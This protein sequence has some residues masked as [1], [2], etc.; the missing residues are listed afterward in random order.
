MCLHRPGPWRGGPGEVV[1]EGAVQ[2][3]GKRIVI[4]G[5]GRGMGEATLGAYVREGASV[6]AIDVRPVDVDRFDGLGKAWYVDCDVSDRAQVDAA[7][8]EA[9]GLLGGLDVLVVT[10][11][12]DLVRPAA[13]I[14]DELW[15][16]TMAINVRGTMLTNQAAYRLMKPAGG[17]A[18]INFGSDSGLVPSMRSAAYS[19]SKAAVHQWTRAIAIEWGPD[20]IRAN[21]VL[22]AIWTPIAEERVAQLSPEDLPK[23]LESVKQRIPLGGKPGDADTDL[24]PV[25]VFLA[26]DGARFITGQMI[27]VNG[28]YGMVR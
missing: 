24:A 17:G 22:P 23:Y 25:M 12:V 10:A 27:A 18:I 5:A 20:G 19:A 9:A 21:A 15:D 11:G 2:L 26:G 16:K 28:G 6:V 13:D 3:S 8:A 4:C 14:D 7:F 1:W